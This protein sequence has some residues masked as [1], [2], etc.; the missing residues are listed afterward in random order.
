MDL[1][2]SDDPEPD[3]V[4]FRNCLPVSLWAYMGQKFCG[5]SIEGNNAQYFANFKIS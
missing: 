1:N 4:V 3:L 5:H 2:V